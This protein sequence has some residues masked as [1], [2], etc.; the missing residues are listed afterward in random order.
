MNFDNVFFPMMF[1]PYGTF[2]DQSDPLIQTIKLLILFSL[3][4][5]FVIIIVKFT[6]YLITKTN[7]KEYPS[8]KNNIKGK[9]ISKKILENYYAEGLNDNDIEYFRDTMATALKEINQIE[10]LGYKNKTLEQLNKTLNMNK[11]LHSFFKAIV[12]KPSK[13]ENA[14]D[15]LYKQLPTLATLYTKYSEIDSHLYKDDET[16]EA[17]EFSKNTINKAYSKI[18]EQYHKFIAEDIETLNDAAN[19]F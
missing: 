11:L 5:S 15:F 2:Y 19:N 6:H 16:I 12:E 4:I 7:F 14:G 13:I 17:L 3:G 18:N 1:D 10:S 8:Y 9:H